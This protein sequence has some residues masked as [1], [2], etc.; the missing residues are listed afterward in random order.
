M[1]WDLRAGLQEE[2]LR[3]GEY[4]SSPTP[5]AE[6]A[7]S[8]EG[9]VN[10]SR[11]GTNSP[12]SHDRHR[13]HRASAEVD[14]SKV[15]RRTVRRRSLATTTM[16][17]VGLGVGDRTIATG[18]CGGFEVTVVDAVVPLTAA[19]ILTTDLF[20]RFGHSRPLRPGPGRQ[21]RP[22]PKRPIRLRDPGVT[23]TVR[24]EWRGQGMY[25]NERVTPGSPARWPTYAR[26]P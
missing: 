4:G 11:D 26:C 17:A 6:V 2:D 1:A 14:S 19:P 15:G 16:R 9:D 12:G 3:P 5:A 25:V 7:V 8:R 20:C 13:R 22:E 18:P 24:D 21:S 10:P 23:A